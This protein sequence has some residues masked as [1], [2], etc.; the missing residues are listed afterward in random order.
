MNDTLTSRPTSRDPIPGHGIRRWMIVG[1]AVLVVAA[2]AL[3]SM[4]RHNDGP[5][6]VH[7]QSFVDTANAKCRAMLANLRPAYVGEGKQPTAQQV[8]SSVDDVA[9]Q[10]DRLANDLRSVSVSAVD[11]APVS[12]WLAQWGSYTAIGHRYAQELRNDDKKAQLDVSREG[13]KVARRADR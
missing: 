6:V 9:G 7:D 8:A 13:D 12:R 2:L 4:P 3:I 5:R 11:Q 10:L 1:G